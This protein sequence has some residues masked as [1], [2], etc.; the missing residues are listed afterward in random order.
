VKPSDKDLQPSCAKAAGQV[1]STRKLVGLNTDQR[2]DRPISREFVGTNDPVDTDRL[3]RIVEDS[4]LYLEIVT[5]RTAALQVFGEAGKASQRVA[6]EDSAEM[7][8]DVAFV[9]IL[10]GLD[11]DHSQALARDSSCR[12]LLRHSFRSS[13]LYVWSQAQKGPL[14]PVPLNHNDSFAF[15]SV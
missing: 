13:S 7:T 10:G 3:D 15:K 2:D 1:G 8:N 6:R 14:S 9:I 11:Q 5:K 12:G 4:D